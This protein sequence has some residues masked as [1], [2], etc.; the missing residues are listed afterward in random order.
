MERWRSSQKVTRVSAV[1]AQ[2]ALRLFDKTF[3]QELNTDLGWFSV[4]KPLQFAVAL[5][6]L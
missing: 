6:I 2:L 1:S 4:C 5:C 3:E